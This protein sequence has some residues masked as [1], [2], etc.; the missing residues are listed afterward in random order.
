MG[1]AAKQKP[2]PGLLPPSP[3]PGCRGHQEGGFSST[4]GSPGGSSGAGA[5][6][7]QSQVR[8][9][10]PTRPSPPHVPL[11]RLPEPCEDAGSGRGRAWRLSPCHCWLPLNEEAGA[12]WCDGRS[13]SAPWQGPAERPGHECCSEGGLSP[14]RCRPWCSQ[15]EA[16]GPDP[17]CSR[18]F[19][20]L[21]RPQPSTASSAHVAPFPHAWIRPPRSPRGQAGLQTPSCCSVMSQVWSGYYGLQ[22]TPPKTPML[23]PQPPILAPQNVTVF[24][25]SVFKG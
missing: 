13:S 15:A 24:R 21:P 18:A 12:G 14:G 25:G 5:D 23:Q 2:Q 4:N 8:S 3:P 7:Q 6:W 1:P 11:Q 20:H 19:Q 17:A 10:V 9:R 22:G 16:A